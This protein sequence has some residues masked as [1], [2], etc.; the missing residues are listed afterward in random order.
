MENFRSTEEI[1][2]GRQETTRQAR[3]FFLA[4]GGAG[5]FIG[6]KI[7]QVIQRKGLGRCHESQLALNRDYTHLPSLRGFE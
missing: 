6:R 7:G 4:A 2:N 1:G 3:I 5:N